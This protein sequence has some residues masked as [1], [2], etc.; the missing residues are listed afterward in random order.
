M[1]LGEASF[2]ESAGIDTG[3]GMALKI[4]TNHRVDR[5]RWR[6]KSG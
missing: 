1:L 6:G 4:D 5:R 3:R 2:E